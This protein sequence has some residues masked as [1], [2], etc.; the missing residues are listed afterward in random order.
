M[1]LAGKVA[2]VTGGGSGI[3]RGI[4][5][6]FAEEG[7][8]V[9]VADLNR[10]GAET[11]AEEIGKLRRRSLVIEADVGSRDDCERMVQETVA[12]FDRLDCFVANAGIGR[13][14]PFLEMPEEVWDAVLRTN[15]TG[16]FLSCQAAA[17]RMVEQGHGGRI[18]T[19]ASVAAE[20]P[21]QGMAN[22]SVSKAGV[23]MLS[24][25]MALEL[26][27][28]RITVNAIGPGVIDTPLA[29]P[30]VAAIKAAERPVAPA[31]RVGAPK[32]VANLALF[33]AS[34]EADY[35][36]GELIFVDGG[37]AIGPRWR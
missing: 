25:V 10:A 24:K 27:P 30:L 5:I 16:V 34:D 9:A 32:D 33:L 14:A 23:A 31:G 18:I 6:R 15:L 35:V 11:T 12:A 8:D 7:A 4:A 19:I 17:R 22:Y 36:T 20:R 1:R 13:G 2:L 29:A 21:A 26:A 3:G 28:H 37:L